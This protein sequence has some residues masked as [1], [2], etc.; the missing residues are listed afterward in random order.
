M[1]LRTFP[2]SLETGHPADTL[3]WAADTFGA[4]ELVVTASFEDAVLVHVAATAVPGIDVVLLDTQYLFA[5]TKWLVAELTKRLD[6]NLRVVHPLDHIQPDNLWQSDV[7]GCCNVRKVEPLQRSL[8]GKAAWV[9]GVRR[10]DGPTRA[11]TPIASFDIGRN[12]VKINPLAGFSDDDMVLY[13]QLHEL[14]ANPL[15]ERGY[16]SIGCWPCTR[17]VAPGEDR[18]GGRWAGNAKTECGLHG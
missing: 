11:N 15:T 1:S 17:P 3:R 18:R 9:T 8:Q 12:I 7:E 10:V 2:E 4:A 6:L 13:A 14:P 16:P 5:E